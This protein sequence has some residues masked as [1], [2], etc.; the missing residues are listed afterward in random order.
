MI[1]T[2]Q[3]YKLNQ[4]PSDS[5]YWAGKT[6]EECLTAT[7]FMVEQYISWNNLPARMDK[8]VFEKID[9]HKEWAEQQHQW[10]NFSVKEK[11]MFYGKA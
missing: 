9:K 2:T 4:A 5:E 11:E 3:K 8:T 7:C 10:D 6:M 1:K